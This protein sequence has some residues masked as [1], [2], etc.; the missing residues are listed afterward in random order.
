MEGGTAVTEGIFDIPHLLGYSQSGSTYANPEG[1][2]P[3]YDIGG[4]YFLSAAQDDFPYQRALT[5]IVKEQFDSSPNPGDNSLQGWWVRTQTDWSL[6][7][8][9]TYMEPIGTDGVARYFLSSAG[10]DVFGSL[11]EVS[12]LP[13][14]S[15]GASAAT[16]ATPRIVEIPNGYVTA[17]GSTVTRVVSGVVST[18]TARGTVTHL[19][20][21]G[22]NVLAC[23]DGY[24]EYAPI[25]GTFNFAD[26]FTTSGYTPRAWYA[27]QRI[28]ITFGPEIHEFA[29]TAI[30]G[31]TNL[32]SATPLFD[33]LDTSMDIVGCTVTPRSI[34]LA[35]NTNTGS[36]IYAITLDTDG[37][38]PASGFPV[39]VA[40][41]PS[42]ENL[43]DIASYLG[44][45]VGIATT[46]GVRVAVTKSDGGVSYGPL[47][48]AP[49]TTSTGNA[50]SAY[51][52]FLHYPVSDAGDGRGGLIRI[53][54][55]EL[56]ED[57][58]CPWATFVRIVAE[59]PVYDGIV[60]GLRTAYLVSSDGSN[61]VLHECSDTVGLDDGWL[62]SS[63][64]R[65][66]TL[67]TKAFD[68]VKVEMSSTGG[69]M[70]VS[71]Y[72]ESGQVSTIGTISQTSDLMDIGARFASSSLALKFTFLP[73]GALGPTLKAWSMRA[74]PSV[75]GRGEDIA[76][77]ML[78]FDYETGGG[79]P[80]GYE[81]RA[82][83]RWQALVDRLTDGTSLRIREFRSG[84]AYTAR[85]DSCT[86]TQTA[87]PVEASGFGGIVNLI[88]R[89]T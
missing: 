37:T 57:G 36:D 43:V 67:E 44:T 86:F 5:K 25:T 51:D 3:D 76:I 88:L 58:R 64:V 42:N 33:M 45:Y 27:K 4:I 65:Y 17:M 70:R 78:N 50:F 49:I 13:L 41:F 79:V 10:V 16:S 6:G 72:T 73:S 34:L 32:I 77:P 21:A 71:S 47:L 63:Y 84:A 66:G 69:E 2:D 83:E 15:T 18:D 48:D 30:S 38:L 82:W 29:G 1:I 28:L 11:G 75:E 60:T 81:G 61:A 89:S 85:V 23:S 20:V 55:S 68:T 53:D 26:A 87:P 9:Q 74:M 12:C 46:R 19:A 31:T 14:A 7:A 39:S 56:Q 8:G 54:L 40:Q 80:N 35:A 62:I 24:V 59:D 52:R 22:P